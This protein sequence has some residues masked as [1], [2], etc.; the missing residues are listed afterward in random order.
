MSISEL[1][2]KVHY[3]PHYL[4]FNSGYPMHIKKN[5]P[6]TVIVRAMEFCSIFDTYLYERENLRVALLLNKYPG[7]FIDKQINQMLTTNNYGIIRE[8]ILNNPCQEKVP[9][10]YCG[11]MFVHFAFYSN[12]NTSQDDDS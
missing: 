8:E 5:I 12:I 1:L 3:I 2:T 4:P 9:I 10:D 11:T 7:E 6:F